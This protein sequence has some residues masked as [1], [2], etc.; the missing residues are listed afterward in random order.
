PSIQP[1]AR[2]QASA[3]PPTPPMPPL[4]PLLTLILRKSPMPTQDA[5]FPDLQE[6][7]TQPKPPGFRYREQIITE[8]EEAALVASLQQLD[9]K[10]FEF[11][12]HLGNR[13]VVSFGLK[14]D[15]SRRAVEPASE[16]PAFL[17]DLLVRVAEFAG[18]PVGAFQQVGVNEYPPNAGIGWHKDKPQFGIVVG[19]SLLAQATM[20]LRR[21]N[22]AKWR[23][24]TQTL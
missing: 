4:P 11:H 24:F 22:G 19:V 10:P 7:P 21:A 1:P 3:L 12:G 2:S 20:R 18:Y 14:Y 16:T 5:L 23:R 8:P 9:L 17:D 13:R 6:K 15:F